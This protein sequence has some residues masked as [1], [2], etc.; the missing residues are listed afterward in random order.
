[1][2]LSTPVF[3]SQWPSMTGIALTID[4]PLTFETFSG[5]LRRLQVR[6]PLWRCCAFLAKSLMKIA[7]LVTSMFFLVGLGKWTGQWW[8][9]E[10]EDAAERIRVD[11][12]P[13]EGPETMK[14]YWE[15][16]MNNLLPVNEET[17]LWAAGFT[18]ESELR[19]HVVIWQ[20]H[21]IGDGASVM[22]LIGDILKE[23][24]A[25]LSKEP[26]PELL[27]TSL[28]ESPYHSLNRT[29]AWK[30][31]PLWR[32]LLP[33]IFNESFDGRFFAGNSRLPFDRACVPSKRTNKALHVSIPAQDLKKFLATCKEKR[34]TVTAALI[35]AFMLACREECD[36]DSG[37]KMSL[38]IP[39]NFRCAGP[40]PLPPKKNPRRGR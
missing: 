28:Y 11:N 25:V 33:R 21:A 29:P 12:I 16:F 5:A 18:S 40:P 27:E 14:K 34:V 36:I 32:R 7:L 1:M 24:D 20:W 17:L 31:L 13:F 38:H 30:Q 37:E 4:G 8:F 19:H 3:F 26:Q 22:K 15:S 35:A 2:K 9:F 6:Q 39:M 10:L 23:C